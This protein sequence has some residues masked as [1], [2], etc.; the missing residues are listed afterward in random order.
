SAEVL[1]IT[2]AGARLHDQDA[3][4]LPLL[5]DFEELEGELDFRT[6][7]VAVTL[8]PA[9]SGTSSI[10]LGEVDI[11]AISFLWCKCNQFY[12]P[13]VDLLTAVDMLSDPLS[14]LVTRNIVPEGAT[15]LISWT[16]LLS[17]IMVGEADKK[18]SSTQ[19]GIF[20]ASSALHAIGV[21]NSDDSVLEFWNITRIREG[22]S[23][24]R[25][26]VCAETKVPARAFFTVS[27]IG[28]SQ[29]PLL[30]SQC[31]RKV[32]SE[33]EI[34]TDYDIVLEQYLPPLSPLLAGFCVDAFSAIKPGVAHSPSS[35][36]DIWD[37]SARA[38]TPMYFDFLRPIQSCRV[39]FKLLGDVTAFAVEPSEQD[40]SGL[41]APLVA[42][43]CKSIKF[44]DAVISV[45]F[46]D[47][48]SE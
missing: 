29:S 10:T 46:R 12:N 19:D 40:D 26:D 18:S 42:A 14:E 20:P 34:F 41:R 2:G 37:K 21:E 32:P 1:A 45:L 5:Y 11:L 23:G 36:S 44:T 3:S 24:A 30:Y 38:G 31:R 4:N 33:A 28:A 35:D 47:K 6:R 39:S 16:N 48:N 8:D 43:E 7:L 13:C 17:N 25:C 22:C 27:S 9:V 15:C